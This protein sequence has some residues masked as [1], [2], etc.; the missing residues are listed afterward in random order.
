MKSFKEWLAEADYYQKMFP[1]ATE[2]PEIDKDFIKRFK[3]PESYARFKSS[4]GRQTGDAAKQ[5][6]SQPASNWFVGEEELVELVPKAFTIPAKRF[7]TR[8]RPEK[9]LAFAHLQTTGPVN[10]NNPQY[11]KPRHR[12]LAYWQG[13]QDTFTK[14]EVMNSISRPVGGVSWVGSYIDN[15]WV[16]DDFRNI[17]PSL[18][19]ALMKAAQRRGAVVD[20]N[21]KL[22]S[23][24]FRAAQAKHDWKRVNQ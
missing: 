14:K 21:D 7:A 5:L 12:L 6:V 11:N 20:P 9:H 18:Y 17:Q 10:P 2:E 24:E 19:G 22:T 3:S 1:F 15:V 8:T 16:D 13:D 4:T 23:K